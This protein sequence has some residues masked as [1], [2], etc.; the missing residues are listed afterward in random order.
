[1]RDRKLTSGGIGKR[2]VIALT[3]ALMLTAATPSLACLAIG[4]VVRVN[5]DSDTNTFP[6]V[7][8]VYVKPRSAGPVSYV[9]L[10]QTIDIGRLIMLTM[11]VGGERVMIRGSNPA[12][13]GNGPVRDGGE[14]VLLNVLDNSH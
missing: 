2:L 1:M 13:V 7:T 14:I 8:S 4:E 11:Q 10:F 5:Y 9:W 6:P 3:T 12:C